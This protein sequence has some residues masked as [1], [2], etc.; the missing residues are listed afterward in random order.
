M[1]A[2]FYVVTA[3]ALA[4]IGAV[5]TGELRAAR[6]T[7]ACAWQVVA[8][9][10]TADLY[11]VSMA[12]SGQGWAVGG[13]STWQ[14]SEGAWVRFADGRW[15]LASSPVAK[16]LVPSDVL[17]LGPDAGWAVANGYETPG[18]YGGKLLRW[19]GSAWSALPGLRYQNYRALGAVAGNEV[20]IAGGGGCC[21][22]YGE[23]L[24]YDGATLQAQ[25][26]AGYPDFPQAL[27]MLAPDQGWAVG[28]LNG[29]ILRYDGQQWQSVTRP[30]QVTLNSLDMLSASQGWAVGD[31]G[32]ILR[33]DGSAWSRV[34][35]PTSA[36]LNDVAAVSADA[37]WAVG[38][39]GS[40]LHWD[41][42]TWSAVPS[43]TSE[44]LYALCMLSPSEGW[45]VG[46]RGTIL[47]FG[48]VYR[49]YLATVR[50][51]YPPT[52]T[53]TH[54]PTPTRLPG[55]GRL[56]LCCDAALNQN[57]ATGYIICWGSTDIRS[58]NQFSWSSGRLLVDLSGT[59][60]A[61]GIAASSQGSTTF[62][63]QLWLVQGS[64]QVLLAQR[65]LVANSATPT[66]YSGVVQGIDPAVRVNQD[67][68][69]LVVRHVAG[70]TGSV[71]FGVPS[72]AEGGGSYVDVPVPASVGA[73]HVVEE[74]GQAPAAP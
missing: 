40:I 4:L 22:T 66:C 57:C 5:V 72:E 26:T 56:Y 51:G 1:R 62:Q 48:P 11:D 65:Y 25:W 58:G 67:S 13:T 15:T 55:S 52:P 17:M 16:E 61:F 14:G 73:Q 18:N 27:D 10:T 23:I 30:A 60:Y 64:N 2:R 39:Q 44:T 45:A 38:G 7:V 20:W 3:I 59:S 32:T 24:H 21:Q 43:P 19:S 35:S 36:G 68:L 33:F 49:S 63:A 29:L 50:R 42:T 9:P 6:Q 74:G 8:S 28:G 31:G 37:A 69:R 34:A 12:S 46:A 41:G 70:A 54:A 71:Y 47:R 53:P